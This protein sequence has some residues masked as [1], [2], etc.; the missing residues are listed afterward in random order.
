MTDNA[1]RFDVQHQPEHSRYVLI[2]TQ[3]EDESQRVI[4]K[5]DYVDVEGGG[6][7]ILFHTEVSEDY[8][9][10][11]LAS[12]LVQHVVDDTIAQGLAIVPVCPYVAKWLPKHPEYDEHVVK[13]TP[14]HLQAVPSRMA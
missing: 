8:A 10:Q 13:P 11:S 14:N 12:V 6:E 2:D 3:V 7:R 1:Q 4:G 9:G 5:E